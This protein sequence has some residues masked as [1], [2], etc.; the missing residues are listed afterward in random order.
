MSHSDPKLQELARC[1]WRIRRWAVRMGEV[2]GQ[3]YVGQALGWSD[4]LAVAYGHALKFKPQDPIGQTATAFCSRMAITRLPF[5][6]P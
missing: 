4:V 1:A 6:P 5:M 3:G 2:Q